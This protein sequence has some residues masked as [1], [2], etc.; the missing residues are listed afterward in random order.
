MLFSYRWRT[1][2]GS[3]RHTW[4]HKFISH[5]SKIS[6]FH[7]MHKRNFSCSTISLPLTFG[8]HRRHAGNKIQISALYFTRFNTAF[9]VQLLRFLRPCLFYFSRLPRIVKGSKFCWWSAFTA[10]ISWE[11][12][13]FKV[14]IIPEHFM[15]QRSEL[16]SPYGVSSKDPSHSILWCYCRCKPYGFAIAFGICDQT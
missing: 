4:L 16:F 11:K 15:E 6:N 7:G 13:W 8:Q 3:V 5:Q 10:T 14:R 12:S 1:L 2:S 9:S